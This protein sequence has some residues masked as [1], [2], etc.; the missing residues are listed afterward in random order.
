MTPTTKKGERS[1]D[2]MV[3]RDSRCRRATLQDTGK[4]GAKKTGK[5]K[6][7]TGQARDS[8]GRFAKTHQ[9]KT[10]I[11]MQLELLKMKQEKLKIDVEELEAQCDKDFAKCEQQQQ[12]KELKMLKKM[13]KDFV[14]LANMVSKLKK[15]CEV[16]SQ[17]Q[18][19]WAARELPKFVQRVG[20]ARE[21]KVELGRV[22]AL[23]QKERE[24]EK[25]RKY[26]N[27]W[28]KFVCA[29]QQQ[30]LKQQAGEWREARESLQQ[31]KTKQA[32][33]Q[34][35]VQEKQS[36]TKKLQVQV[37]NSEKNARDWEKKFYDLIKTAW[38]AARGDQR[39]RAV[40][41]EAMEARIK[42]LITTCISNEKLIKN[43]VAENYELSK[44][45]HYRGKGGNKG[46]HRGKGV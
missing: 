18:R 27:R 26:D 3:F 41:V 32:R 8:Q 23:K 24:E 37:A 6:T 11:E 10:K 46:G 4:I 30:L 13:A 38:K 14:W 39:V 40:T 7:G 34:Q 44:V 31:A 20:E 28:L 29:A 16:G 5:E 36:E 43:L 22:A 17:S 45:K 35:L 19:R 2:R 21:A 1:R 12:K 9:K 25:K 15:K 42:G 33:A